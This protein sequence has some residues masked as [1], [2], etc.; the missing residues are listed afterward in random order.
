MHLQ[1]LWRIFLLPGVRM[2]KRKIEKFCQRF[3]IIISSLTEQVLFEFGPDYHNQNF[4]KR[5]PSLIVYN[6]LV[7]PTAEYIFCEKNP[8]VVAYKPV[9]LLTFQIFQIFQE[10]KYFFLCFSTSWK[11]VFYGIQI[12][13]KLFSM[14][15][16]FWKE[17]FYA[18][19]LLEKVILWF[20]VYTLG[21]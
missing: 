10:M 1:F 4:D 14:L 12:F 11:M 3:K 8:T 5:L 21:S 6:S 13:E 9:L 19:H 20:S 15:F 17:N 7:F 18:F 2:E 16:R